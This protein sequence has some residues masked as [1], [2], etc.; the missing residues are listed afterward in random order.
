MKVEKEN[1]KSEDLWKTVAIIGAA[2]KM[3]RGISLLV[4]QQ[5]ALTHARHEGKNVNGCQCYLIDSDAEGLYSLRNF[6]KKQIRTFG[7]KNI[8]LLRKAYEDNPKLVSNEE[9]IDV[10][11]EGAMDVLRFDSDPLQAKSSHLIFEAIIENVEAKTAIFKDLQKACGPETYFFTNTSSIPI[12]ELSSRSQLKG[13]LIGFHFYNPPHIQKLVELIPEEDTPQKLL[14]TA[15]LVGKSLD[16]KLVKS[17]DVAGFI[18]N[19]H[20]IR[21]ISYAIEQVEQLARHLAS[22]EAILIMNEIT[23]HY[24]IRPMGIFQLIDYVGLDIC[25]QVAAIMEEYAPGSHFKTDLILK[26]IEK[27]KKGGQ[28]FDGSQKDGFFRYK[29]L[30]P[31]EYYHLEK[32]EYLPL[33]ETVLEGIRRELGP[34]PKGHFTWH[35]A[36]KQHGLNKAL[37]SYFHNL[38]ESEEWGAQLAVNFLHESEA[39]V[40]TLVKEGIAENFNDVK[41]VLEKGFYHL[42]APGDEVSAPALLHYARNQKRL[43]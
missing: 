15:T 23:H 1:Q 29:D 36:K 16:K 18:G 4:L 2:G 25:K 42:Y 35:Q 33:T 20:F 34:L 40:Q 12:H 37:E 9:M 17:K 7:E 24:L 11:V 13:R 22:S 30:H 39:I 14:D 41:I 8:N 10:F 21:E 43:S 28:R 3:G 6:L 38:G 26:L 27:G 32:E 31:I 19:G 5:V